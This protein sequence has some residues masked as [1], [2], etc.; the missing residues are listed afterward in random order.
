MPPF[1]VHF[2][3]LPDPRVDR[4]KLHAL[5]DILVIALCTVICGGEGWEDM[6]EFGHAKE[7]FL[8]EQL[9]LSLP[10]GIPS[11]DTF[12]RVFAR[13]DPDA[14]TRCF[15]AWVA[16]LR[17]QTKG[18]VVS[19][20]GKALRHS[21]DTAT[22]QAPLHVISAWAGK[23]RLVLCQLK[24]ADK[25]NEIPAIPVLLALL[26]LRGCTVTID[27]MGCQKA[28]AQRIIAQG[29]D[30][31]L[32]LK[33]NQ[34]TLHADVAEFFED[35]RAR[36]FV[37][38]AHQ[39]TETLDKDHGRL[40]KRRY[41][42]V[43]EVEWLVARHDWAGLSSIS[44][45]ER[46]RQVGDAVTSEVSYTINSLTGSVVKLARAARGHWG[47]ENQVHHVLDVTFDEDDCRIR[48]ENA[49]QNLAT[50]RHLAL[51]LLRQEPT[52]RRGIKGRI[53]RAGWDDDYLLRVLAPQC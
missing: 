1:A 26:D 47:I 22:G 7:P 49:P 14:F 21:F 48:K 13:L 16:T 35:A 40:E 11:P 4:T 23:N 6:S 8:R 30:Y 31:V 25:S 38:V 5:L 12:R 51:N 53:R 44:M 52:H 45:I 46:I 29:G 20:D 41:W 10:N 9:G 24:V 19:I 37:G 39:Y 27:A 36:G 18:E 34:G 15:T 28:V 17:R 2:A 42:L 43:E 33:G 50:V 3:D 32:A